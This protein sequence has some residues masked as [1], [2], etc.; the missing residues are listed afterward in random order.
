MHNTIAALIPID[1]GK[2][3]KLLLLLSKFFR[4]T[5][6]KD[7]V[8]VH[9]L[10]DELEI[11]RT[12][13]DMQQIRYGNRMRYTIHT[14][15]DALRLQVP[16]F[17][18]QPIVENAFKHGIEVSSANGFVSIEIALQPNTMLIT[19]ADSGPAFPEHP[20][21]GMGLRIV[22]DKLRLLYANDFKIELNNP[23]HKYVRL[24]IPATH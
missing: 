11:T 4:S 20:R 2:A 8:T 9:P 18:L 6:D 10:T 16:S 1:P 3:E 13:L 7:S 5:L 19:V 22:M 24:T 23:P 17:V 21:S 15:P 14:D 12:Y